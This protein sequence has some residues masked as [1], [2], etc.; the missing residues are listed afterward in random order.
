[1]CAMGLLLRRDIHSLFDTGL[2]YGYARIISF[3]VSE[4]LVEEFG[5]GKIYYEL[6]KKLQGESINLPTQDTE[7]PDRD[8]LCW[9]NN[10]IYLG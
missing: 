2:C 5:N 3:K 4:R 9:H 10:N 8:A 1:M 6:Q 7:K